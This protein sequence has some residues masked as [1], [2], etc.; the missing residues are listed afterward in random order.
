MNIRKLKTKKFNAVSLI[1]LLT[2]LLYGCATDG[3]KLA[4]QI[5]G[6]V[7]GALG[8]MLAGDEIA[9]Q[10]GA[11]DKKK[12]KI[13]GG[14]LG[15]LGGAAVAG[16]IY[17]KLSEDGKRNREFALLEAAK[18]AKIQRYTDPHNPDIS[19]IVTPGEPSIAGPLECVVNED[20][21]ADQNAGEKTF[22]KFCRDVP[23]GDWI[24]YA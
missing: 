20:V 6:C 15:C 21:L 11:S 23:D 12:Y 10:T 22:E 16:A 1:I 24:K 18:T 4:A 8:G 13:A 19:G 14:V 2:S 3:G 7:P 5:T 9:K 17:S